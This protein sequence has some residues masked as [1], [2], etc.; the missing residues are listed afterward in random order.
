MTLE[1]HLI[2]ELSKSSPGAVAL[3]KVVSLAVLIEPQLLRRARIKLLPDVDAGAEA[4]LWLSTLV[5]T[6]SPRGITLMPRAAEQLRRT[7]SEDSIL[8][9][10]AWKL[11]AEAHKSS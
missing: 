1:E 6:R 10:K 3:A 8:F 5:Q 7:L 11:T 9:D 2:E 4:D